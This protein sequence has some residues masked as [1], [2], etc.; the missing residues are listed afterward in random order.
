MDIVFIADGIHTLVD[1]VI[2]DPTHAHLVSQVTSSQGM[3]VTIA[4]QAKLVSYYNR[5]PKDDFIPL[6]IKIFG[7]LH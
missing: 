7:C 2:I 6:T 5:H 1:I 3:V 4:A